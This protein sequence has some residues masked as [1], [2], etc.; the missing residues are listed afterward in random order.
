MSGVTTAVLATAAVASVGASLSQANKAKKIAKR[1]AAIAEENRIKDQQATQAV[2]D[3]QQKTKAKR[4]N[5][6]AT[7]GGVSGQELQVGQVQQR[8]TL[9]GN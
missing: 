7:G 2:N 8:Q 5:L 1:D 4:V 6:F 9:L 3:N